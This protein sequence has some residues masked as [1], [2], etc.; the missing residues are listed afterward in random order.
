MS[1]VAVEQQQPFPGQPLSILELQIVTFLAGGLT[2]PGVAVALHVSGSAV[3]RYLAEMAVKLGTSD[4]A[5]MVGAAYR[6][7]QLRVESPGSTEL[8]GHL[9]QVLIGIARGR[10]NAEMAAELLISEHA[11]KSRV[12]VLLRRLGVHDRASAVRAGLECGAL[13]LV[14]RARAGVAR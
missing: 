3:K 5:G 4:R 12:V 6:T 8:D 9:T 10:S 7:R 2:N 11:V 13:T 14:P 1:A